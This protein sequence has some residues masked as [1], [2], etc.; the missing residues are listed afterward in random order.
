MPDIRKSLSMGEKWSP[1][2]GVQPGTRT[3][4]KPKSVWKR[5]TLSDRIEWLPDGGVSYLGLKV[6]SPLPEAEQKP[7]GFLGEMGDQIDYYFHQR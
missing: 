1:N 2:A 7:F 6:L 3:I 4:I 5:E